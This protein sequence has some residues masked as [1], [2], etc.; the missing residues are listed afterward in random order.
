VSGANAGMHLV[1]WLR[2]LPAA[3]VGAIARAAA[4][5]GVGIYPVSAFYDA[6]P[7]RAGLL[8]GYA[9]LEERDIRIGVER[10]A[11]LL[12]ARDRRKPGRHRKAM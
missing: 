10:L 6:P 9:A 11:R 2:D 5:V 1:V 12:A 8:L 4:E 7:A 3:Q